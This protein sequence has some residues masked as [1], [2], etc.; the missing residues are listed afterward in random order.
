M[1]CCSVTMNASGGGTEASGR[2][3][4]SHYGSREQQPN[5][6]RHRWNMIRPAKMIS[7]TAGRFPFYGPTKPFRPCVEIARVAMK[8]HPL[9]RRSNKTRRSL[10]TISLYLDS[11]RRANPGYSSSHQKAVQAKAIKS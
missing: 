5:L 9:R 6:R 8:L 1:E 2:N 3:P 7:E 10:D 11:R 4:T